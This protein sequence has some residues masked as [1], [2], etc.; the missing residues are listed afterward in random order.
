MSISAV[1]T[2]TATVSWQTPLVDFP[3]DLTVISQY[4]IQANP[5]YFDI[6]EVSGLTDANTLVYTFPN[7]LEEF[8][9]YTVTVKAINSFGIGEASIDVQLHT[10]QAGMLTLQNVVFALN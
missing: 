4:F 7:N 2:R 1:G 9:T 3:N 6:D 5:Y 8:V 10:L